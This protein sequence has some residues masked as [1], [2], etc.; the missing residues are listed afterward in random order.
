M[1]VFRPRWPTI[2]R[3]RWVGTIPTYQYARPDS[4][5][6][7]GNWVNESL[8]NTN[9]YA[10]IDETIAND[11]DYIQSS[12]SPAPVDITEIGL[13]NVTDPTVHTGHIVRYR[14]KK[15]AAGGDAINLVVRLMQ[16]S[17]E[18]AS[19]QHMDITDSYQ[20]AAQVLTTTQAGNISDYTDLRLRFEAYGPLG[21]GLPAR[22]AQSPGST[23]Y[24]SPSG[25]DGTGDGSFGNPWLQ[26]EF[27]VSQ[28]PYG[29]IIK[30]MPGTYNLAA[31]EQGFLD[32][33]PSNQ[34]ITIEAN[35]PL[36]KPIFSNGRFYINGASYFRFKNLKITGSAND[37]VKFNGN[38][39]HIELDGCEVYSN[40]QQG[41]IYT[42]DV[43]GSPSEIQIWNCIVRDNGSDSG[44]HHGIYIADLAGTALTS[45][46][47][48][49]VIYDNAA[50][51]IQAYPNSDGALITCCTI[52]SNNGRS[53]MV[54]GGSS[55]TATDNL[56]VVGGLFTNNAVHA[57]RVNWEGTAGTN[58]NVYDVISYNN[59][60]ATEFQAGTNVT[61]TRCV[62]QDPLYTN[63]GTH[64][65]T[66]QNGSPAIGYIDPARW[67]YVPKTDFNGNSRVMA[68]CGAYAKN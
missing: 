14:Y 15:D 22:I 24:I 25:N 43:S 59:A 7:D 61:Y 29:S 57:V 3:R 23:Y 50:Y 68:T 67:Q 49:C 62:E 2:P 26:P 1:T 21:N 11:S 8:S 47:A 46:I 35:D 12:T 39:N 13:S 42:S 17:T 41:I 20:V 32:D 27:A 5:I 66:L 44:L 40:A 52:D 45:I 63:A 65:Y 48:N 30:A 10:S 6:T 56:V 64:D 58:N 28:V 38:A 34:P 60:D 54:I 18:I 53:A 16:G 36:D 51:G 31:D 55:T 4:D 9:L 33:C 37:G 19:W